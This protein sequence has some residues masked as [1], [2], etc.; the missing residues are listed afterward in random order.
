MV[1][2]CVNSDEFIPQLQR[3]PSGIGIEAA[4]P[5]L[6]IAKAH[7]IAQVLPTEPGGNWGRLGTLFGNGCDFLR[8]LRIRK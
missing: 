4:M 5:H 8:R 2:V 7:E 3:A 6:L 1:S